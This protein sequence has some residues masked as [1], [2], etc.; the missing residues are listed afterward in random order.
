ML[1]FLKGASPF[2]GRM[3]KWGA[4]GAGAGALYGGASGWYNGTGAIGGA[5]GGAMQGAM[6]GV[7]AGFL[8]T[9]LKMGARA[10]QRTGGSLA[11][12]LGAGVMASGSVMA[13]QG[14]ASA[15]F[16]GNTLTKA[17]NRI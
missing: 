10:F 9:P 14:R 7:G 5:I 12:R 11:Q 15:G 13:A 2:L 4:I 8:R 17:I 3:G 6:L 1:G 16:I